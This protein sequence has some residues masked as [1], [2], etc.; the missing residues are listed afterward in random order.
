MQFYAHRLQ[1]R[2]NEGML[3]YYGRLF[4]QYIVDMY[5]KVEHR[6]LEFLRNNQGALRTELYSGLT[7]AA[8]SDSTTSTEEIGRQIILL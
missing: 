5:V 4:H 8:A 6:R 3:H 1:V 7:D 2:P